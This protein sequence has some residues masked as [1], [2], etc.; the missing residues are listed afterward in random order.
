LDGV[1]FALARFRRFMPAEARSPRMEEYGGHAVTCN[2][3]EMG[4]LLQSVS[5]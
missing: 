2:P 3:A 1:N 5:K 4:K